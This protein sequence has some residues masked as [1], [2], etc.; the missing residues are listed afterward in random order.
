MLAQKNGCGTRVTHAR[1]LGDFL[2]RLW[3]GAHGS[4]GSR[5]EAR[6]RSRSR[7]LVPS[8]AQGR[9]SRRG[10]GCVYTADVAELRHRAQGPRHIL[11][12]CVHT[13]NILWACYLPPQPGTSARASGTQ[14]FDV[15]LC[16]LSVCWSSVCLPLILDCFSGVF[17]QDIKSLGLRV[18]PIWVH[19]LT[20]LLPGYVTYDSCLY[21]PHLDFWNPRKDMRIALWF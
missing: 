13:L 10:G 9:Q 11:P 21:F 5:G 6:S 19:I 14:L 16:K 18:T 4:F 12:K 8:L 7:G 17:R 15:S 3:L 1:Y 20:G 2:R